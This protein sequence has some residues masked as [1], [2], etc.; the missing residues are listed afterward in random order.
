[1]NQEC[2]PGLVRAWMLP[3]LRCHETG[4]RFTL[5]LAGGEGP[6][7]AA[8]AVSLPS[9]EA[10]KTGAIP[11]WGRGWK[12]SG[13]IQAIAGGSLTHAAV[14]LVAQRIGKSGPPKPNVLTFSNDDVDQLPF[15]FSLWGKLSANQANVICPRWGIKLPA[16]QGNFHARLERKQTAGDR[17][18]LESAVAQAVGYLASRC[19]GM[20]KLEP[21]E[22]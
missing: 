13:T 4:Q 10:F 3:L 15:D 14:G 21:M 9:H 6:L 8:G 11:G 1:M 12:T 2:Y 22:F 7:S 19:P 5:H 17:Q 16:K 18:L 20:N